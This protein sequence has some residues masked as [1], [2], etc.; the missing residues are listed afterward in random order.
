MPFVQVMFIELVLYIV[1]ALSDA[2]NSIIK[3]TVPF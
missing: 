1:Y 3:D 2:K